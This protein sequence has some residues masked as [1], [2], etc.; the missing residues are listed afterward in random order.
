[1][2]IEEVKK[3]MLEIAEI[4]N[5]FPENLQEKAFDVMVYQLWNIDTI[6]LPSIDGAEE[7]AISE[8]APKD[9][10]KESSVEKRIVLRKFTKLIRI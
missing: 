5:K 1:M 10:E 2:K 3:I 7:E 8:I 6:E 4:L 9:S